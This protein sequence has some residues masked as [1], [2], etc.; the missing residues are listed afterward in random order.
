MT[1]MR[2]VQDGDPLKY[3]ARTH[4]AF[5]DAALHVQAIKESGRPPI[6]LDFPHDGTFW[7]RNN[8]GELVDRYGVLGI[9]SP[10]FNPRTEFDSFSQQI[11]LDGAEPDEYLHSGKFVILQEP[12][13]DGA[14]GRCWG[15]GIAPCCLDP[16]T[17]DGATHA[18]V[19]TSNFELLQG[20]NT[21]FPIVWVDDT[22][23]SD[24]RWALIRF[25]GVSSGLVLMQY[26]GYSGL[27][28]GSDMQVAGPTALYNMT[29][30][31]ICHITRHV[32]YPLDDEVPYDAEDVNVWFHQLNPRAFI[33]PYKT[34]WA[35]QRGTDWYAVTGGLT[36]FLM[37]TDADVGPDMPNEI[38]TPPL[39]VV[40]ACD[41]VI[42][43][44]STVLITFMDADPGGLQPHAIPICPS[45][46]GGSGT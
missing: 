39:G 31:G 13:E 17:A 8:S 35:Q 44:G 46:C 32:S 38:G 41:E 19:I 36:D 15:S 1:Y 6:G 12:L 30:Y 37:V 29:N 9:D 14:V 24:K 5:I 42:P 16:A 22:D 26:T 10:T 3:P 33:Y 11:I 45:G 7:V 28:T 20:G 40:P 2:H 25:G 21:G 27:G 18:D 23:D 43:S 4:N 34:F